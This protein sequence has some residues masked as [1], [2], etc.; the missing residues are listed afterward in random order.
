MSFSKEESVIPNEHLSFDQIRGAAGAGPSSLPPV[1]S[2]H[3]GDCRQ[4]A[5]L[6]KFVN[7]LGAVKPDPATDLGDC[8]SQVVLLEIAEGF[9]VPDPTLYRHIAQCQRCV[10]ALREFS[11]DLKDENL[12]E[13]K[14]LRTASPVWQRALAEKIVSSA[15]TKFPGP[16]RL[17]LAWRYAIAAAAVV[18]LIAGGMVI[19]S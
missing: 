19:R 15:E 2:A 18:V 4:C 13:T 7:G 5:E 10:I 11:E 17:R 9:T 16:R 12:P 3:L 6:V 14:D 8:P 1:A